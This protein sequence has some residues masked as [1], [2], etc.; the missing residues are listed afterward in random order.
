MCAASGDLQYMY[1]HPTFTSTELS[2]GIK[3]IIL[4]TDILLCVCAR[5]KIIRASALLL[6]IVVLCDAT[7]TKL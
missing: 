4:C 2:R 6:T 3:E 7:T 1:I 5:E